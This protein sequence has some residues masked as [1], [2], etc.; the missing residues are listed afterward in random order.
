MQ[1][2][3]RVRSLSAERCPVQLFTGPDVSCGKRPMATLD[4]PILYVLLS[5]EL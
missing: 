4:L 5:R 2:S 1:S 3:G